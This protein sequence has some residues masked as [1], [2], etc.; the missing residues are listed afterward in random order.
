MDN[1]IKWLFFCNRL[2]CSPLE[3]IYM[4]LI[5]ILSKELD[6]TLIQLTILAAT[7]PLASLFAF[8]LN[9]LIINKT[10]RIRS[11]LISLNIIGCLSCFLFPFTE[12]SWFFIA[13]YLIFMIALRSSFPAWMEILKKD[14]GLND[15]GG[16]IANGSSIN[17]MMIM[18]VPILIA[19]LL[20]S[21]YPGM[22]KIL[23]FGMALLQL[24]NTA[25]LFCLNCKSDEKSISSSFSI[26]SIILSP[27]KDAWELCAKNKAF[28]NYLAMFF[29]GGAGLVAMQPIL[30]VFFK[31][32]LHL[33]YQELTI[34]ISLCK[35]IGFVFTSSLWAK[36][37][38]N[39]YTLNACVNFLSCLFI[40]FLMMSEAYA[41]CIFTAFLIYGIMQSG[42]EL[43][44]SVS[45]P[46]FSKNN[47]SISYSG[48]N[49][50]IVGLRAC[51]FPTMGQLLFAYSNAW[52]VFIFSGVL[53]F[54]G[55]LYALALFKEYPTQEKIIA[56]RA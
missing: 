35:G 18:I 10:H 33:S 6:A 12:S 46:L 40:A 15:L 13:S 41:F 42:C 38:K 1:K 56:I 20:D 47:E 43:S 50:A 44:Y 4:L 32:N 9:T 48:M 45:G 54:L 55:A 23:F 2:L 22:W 29:L 39:I 28:T 17:F 3:A 16:V 11:Y 5:F 52:M 7:K 36:W 8:Y 37:N 31:E 49:L 25:L 27:W 26:G 14:L 51:I 53:C 30:P 24:L 34:A 21:P 19:P